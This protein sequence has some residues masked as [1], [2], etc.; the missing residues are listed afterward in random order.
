MVCVEFLSF[1]VDVGVC[2]EAVGATCLMFTTT[3]LPVVVLSAIRAFLLS[4]TEFRGASE[5]EAFK[6][7]G[8]NYKIFYFAHAP[9]KFD[10]PKGD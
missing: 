9:V 7:S 6:A 5:A 4:M 3:L 1:F 10:F 8:D 2:F